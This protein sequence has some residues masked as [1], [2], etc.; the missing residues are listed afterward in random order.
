MST[1]NLTTL[2]VIAWNTG[3]SYTAEGQRIAAAQTPW[4]VVFVD[5]DRMIDGWIA[6]G[7]FSQSAVMDAYDHNR[8]THGG[9][10]L[11]VSYEDRAAVRS[12]LHVAASRL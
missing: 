7:T 10:P 2:P 6:D 11:S 4:G 5:Y 9:G 8:Y 12:Q 3:R 1:L